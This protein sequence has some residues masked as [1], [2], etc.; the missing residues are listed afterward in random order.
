MI[1]NINKQ[2][3]LQ[4]SISEN[5]GKSLGTGARYIGKGIRPILTVANNGRKELNKVKRYTF[6]KGLEGIGNAFK[7]TKD[8]AVNFKKG[9]TD[10]S[11]TK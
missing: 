9:L 8:V 1:I 4:E 3:V 11:S 10:D 6:N 2:D 5:I 7:V